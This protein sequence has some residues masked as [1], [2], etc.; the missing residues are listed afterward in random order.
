MSDTILE[1]VN[2]AVATITTIAT[3]IP[4]VGTVV[5]VAK[6]C[7]QIYD[8]TTAASRT[9]KKNKE[10][11][12]KYLNVVMLFYLFLRNVHKHTNEMVTSQKVNKMV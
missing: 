8:V 3:A 10:N 7:K 2:V 11:C 12:K 5:S 4:V 9:S 6:T 1:A